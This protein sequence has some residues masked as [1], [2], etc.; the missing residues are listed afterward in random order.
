MDD[1]GVIYGPYEYYHNENNEPMFRQ[2]KVRSL[3]T[4]L[5]KE[6]RPHNFTLE[7]F[8]SWL[9]RVVEIPENEWTFI[10]IWGRLSEFLLSHFHDNKIHEYLFQLGKSPLYIYTRTLEIIESYEE[11]LND[12]TCDKEFTIKILNK[13]NDLLN[14]CEKYISK[15]DKR[16]AIKLKWY[17][18]D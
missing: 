4:L 13:Y 5:E 11:D 17:I 9:K 1:E 14:I 2:W 15:E 6:D 18:G 12:S 7:Q 16:I 3:A 10:N 8:K